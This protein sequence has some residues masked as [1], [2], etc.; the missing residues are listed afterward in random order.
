MKTLYLLRHA[1]S[2]WGNASISDFER[3]LND[4]G[5]AVA[6]DLGKTLKKEGLIPDLVISSPAVRTKQTL[7]CLQKGMEMSLYSQYPKILY[8][9]SEE[10]IL[11]TIRNAAN[12][13]DRMMIIGHNP[14]LHQLAISL[15]KP[16]GT[17]SMD[18]LENKFSAGTFVEITF[19]VDTWID[20]GTKDGRLSRLIKPRIL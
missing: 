15:A 19:A 3:T 10:S 17:H 4:H 9:G 14:G 16:G 6:E 7:I 18:N 13:S 12:T 1:K 2:N 20:V 5:R 8:L 11:S